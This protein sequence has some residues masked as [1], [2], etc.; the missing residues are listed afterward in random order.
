[1]IA[2]LTVANKD[3][4]SKFEKIHSKKEVS[5][6]QAKSST[7]ELERVKVELKQQGISFA[8]QHSQETREI[9]GLKV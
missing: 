9:R 6:H 1:M 4:E 3:W 7:K 2:K 5:D 8:E